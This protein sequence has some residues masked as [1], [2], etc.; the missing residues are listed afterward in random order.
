MRPSTNAPTLGQ[1]P[2][3]AS[4]SADAPAAETSP[5]LLGTFPSAACKRKDNRDF[6]GHAEAEGVAEGV[7]SRRCRS[8][9]VAGNRASNGAR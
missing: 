4:A 3:R 8:V 2:T 1:P 5:E 9:T 6:A 7:P